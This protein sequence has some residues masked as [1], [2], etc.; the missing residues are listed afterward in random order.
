MVNSVAFKGL[1]SN[2]QRH[3]YLLFELA[4]V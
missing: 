2:Q 4:C 1:G 3:G